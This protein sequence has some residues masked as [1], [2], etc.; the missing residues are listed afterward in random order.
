M[1]LFA[2]AIYPND[3]QAYIPKSQWVDRFNLYYINEE[4]LLQK[5]MPKD[6][7]NLYC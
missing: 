4:A 6:I 3:F 5:S 1:A 2:G 7:W